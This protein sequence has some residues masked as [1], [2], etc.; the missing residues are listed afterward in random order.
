MA[1]TGSIIYHQGAFASEQLDLRF[2][3]VESGYNGSFYGLLSGPHGET[4]VTPTDI[5]VHVYRD[6]LLLHRM[7]SRGAWYKPEDYD[8]TRFPRRLLLKLEDFS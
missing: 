7:R 4:S 3:E 1:F 8:K 2:E 5:V 6:G